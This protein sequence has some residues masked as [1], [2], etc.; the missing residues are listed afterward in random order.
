MKAILVPTDLN[1]H[2]A[3]TLQTARLLAAKFDATIEGVALRPAFA[4]V[5]APDPIVA[6][7]IPPA[8]WSEDDFMRKTRALFDGVA[9]KPMDGGQMRWRGGPS[10]DDVGLGS[11]G[12]VNDVTVM[13]RPGRNGSRMTS[14]EAAL[15]DS[16]R[17]VL[18]APPIAKATFG[19]SIAIHWNAS[20]ETARVI[21]AA[22][23][24]LKQAKRVLLIA[25]TGHISPG[26]SI[27][28]ALSHLEAHGIKAIERT[29][30][31][32]PGPGEAILAE[33]ATFGADLLVKGAYTQSRLRQMIFGGA[34]NHILSSAEIPVLFMH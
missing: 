12:R 18:M 9:S 32:R 33:A 16:G 17:P 20:T 10:V 31:P 1:E 21:G 11:L 3:A 13:A 34:T 23:P 26:P 29:V 7:T 27:K 5:V 14:F 30:Q 4:E 24:I 6:V 2:M 19:D 28:E 25:V 15:F 8:D 22:L